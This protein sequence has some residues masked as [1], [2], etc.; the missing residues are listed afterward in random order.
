[1]NDQEKLTEEL[2]TELDELRRRNAELE[3]AEAQCRE[4]EEELKRER[5]LFIG[6]P[7]VILKTAAT[8]DWPV[9]YVSPNIVQFGYQPEDLLSGRIPYSTI[10]HPDDLGKVEE[11]VV[12]YSQNGEVETFEQD[13]RIV[14]PDGAVR[15]VYDFTIIV[16]DDRGQ[17]TH[18]EG[19]I[20]DIT[21]RKEAQMELEESYQ[22]LYENAIVGLARTRMSDGKILA[23]NEYLARMMGYENAEVFQD[24]FI[25]SEHYVDAGT[26]ED[27]LA[28]LQEQGYLD[29]FEVR[30]FR[31]D[32]SIMWASYSITINQ[33]K[34]FLEVVVIDIT[35]RKQVEEEQERLQQE[36]IEAQQQAIQELSTPI[37]PLTDEIIILPL[38]GTIDKRR[39]RTILRSLLEGIDRHLAR[40]VIFDITGVGIIDSQV[41]VHLDRAI[42]AARLKGA[43]VLITGVTNPVAETIVELAIEWEQYKTYRNLQTAIK[44][45]FAQGG[46]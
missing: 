41:A 25:F 40:T 31:Q 6:G 18:H 32:G 12:N 37:I 17:I 42:K 39:A 16:R 34:G 14:R 15:W 22:S 13:Y 24:K 29:N 20:L 19:Y 27:M 23:C 4:I 7:V 10:I 38:I 43:E 9:E 36:L 30:L 1:M 44:A 21:E 8:D 3:T 11:E 26:R 35:K 46:N 45:V 2:L 28:A 5:R 33:N